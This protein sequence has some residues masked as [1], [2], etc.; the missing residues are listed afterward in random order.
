MSYFA[1]RSGRRRRGLAAAATLVAGT[2]FAT[3]A[4]S[5]A[6]GDSSH[7]VAAAAGRFDGVRLEQ[8]AAEQLDRVGLVGLDT[9]DPV[10]LA[11][12]VAMYEFADGMWWGARVLIDADG[13]YVLAPLYPADPATGGTLELHLSDGEHFGPALPLEVLAMTEAPGAFATA[14]D[15]VVTTIDAAAAEHGSSWDELA[16][17]APAA[18]PAELVPLKLAQVFV[19]DPTYASATAAYAVLD[20]ADAA[21]VDAIFAKLDLADGLDAEHFAAEAARWPEQIAVV[22]HTTTA[23]PT[24]GLLP[25]TST[26]PGIAA[27]SWSTRRPRQAS[28]CI[29]FF[30]E[31]G[32]QVSP[33]RLSEMMV[34]TAISDIAINTSGA[35]GRTFAA[36]E[37]TVT[38]GAV[39]EAGAS[40]GKSPVFATVGK[41][42][43]G[44]KMFHALRTGLLPTAFTDIDVTLDPGDLEED[45]PD[46]APGT[47][48]TVQVTAASR[49]YSLDADVAG[50]AIDALGGSLMESRL[51]AGSGA[52]DDAVA[53]FHRLDDAVNVSDLNT[54]G[55]AEP[56]KNAVNDLLPGGV[57]TFCP[58][59]FTADLGSGPW[60]WAR[61]RQALLTVDNDALTY[62]NTTEIGNDTLAIGPIPAKFGQRSIYADVPVA[63]RAI[64]VSIE[65]DVIYVPRPGEQVT[66]TAT[67]EHAYDTRLGWYADRGEWANGGG[68]I[69][70][71]DSDTLTL[72]TPESADEFPD[73]GI[74][75]E[76]ESLSRTG[77]RAPDGDP[78]RYDVVHIQLAPFTISP[79][80]GR[81]LTGQQVGFQA[82]DANGQPIGV[83]W[84]ASGGTI[85]GGPAAT[86]VYTAGAQP[87]TYTVTAWLPGH[88]DE[89]V[90]AT[91]IIGER[92]CVVGTWALDVP[93]FMAL[94]NQFAEGGSVTY[95]SGDSTVVVRDDATATWTMNDV[96]FRISQD[97]QALTMIWNSVVDNAYLADGFWQGQG[98]TAVVDVE[99]VEYGF[100]QVMNVESAFSEAAAYDCEPGES[101]VIHGADGDLFLT[102]IGPP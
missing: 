26:P 43:A 76:V 98:G 1:S 8:S 86:S 54:A 22:E 99:V 24:D 41:G 36:F 5:T 101:L 13:P 10:A 7:N 59:T 89:P 31:G 30:Q 47:W 25:G 2:L 94:M 100:S 18:V 84:D 16:A 4:A 53:W 79:D 42:A 72:F 12:V 15:A 83:Q 21:L 46:S 66:I 58:Q 80:P 51:P 87:G 17:T 33:Q 6:A 56:I 39:L 38:L 40:G 91:V 63:T 102:Y 78:P 96:T 49:G 45:R 11:E 97:G 68:A 29:E 37:A 85:T 27:P 70:T 82:T 67:I 65:P 57:I 75:I 69:E 92:D 20:P 74:R 64:A 60:T 73:G 44:W 71:P 61:P 3:A 81:V 95:L 50:L 9:E 34:G 77:L 32:G 48:P 28:G 19:D 23:A 52:A 90:I 55:G 93:R 88:P 35:P 62:V 14:V